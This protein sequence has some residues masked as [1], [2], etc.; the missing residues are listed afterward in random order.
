[1]GTPSCTHVQ[2]DQ[3]EGAA[4]AERDLHRHL[5]AAEAEAHS[6]S[7]ETLPSNPMC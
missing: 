2:R 4:A 3:L 5:A 6:E 7:A 1:M